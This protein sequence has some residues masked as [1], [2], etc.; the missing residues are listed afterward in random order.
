MNRQSRGYSLLAVD[1]LDLDRWLELAGSWIGG[2][3]Y[4]DANGRGYGVKQW[5]Y[6]DIYAEDE[7]D[8]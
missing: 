2:W 1:N 8:E 3:R 5:Q 4:N 6:E 7:Y